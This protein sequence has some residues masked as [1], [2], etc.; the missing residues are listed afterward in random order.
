M[1]VDPAMDAGAVGGDSLP[2]LRPVLVTHPSVET[3]HERWLQVPT[4]SGWWLIDL[5][6]ARLCRTEQ[7]HDPRFLDADH[8][9]PF[10]RVHVGLERIEA[11]LSAGERISALVRSV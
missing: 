5:Q 11:E 2:G 4:T 1:T 3:V 7:A 9:L 10:A 8:W 6:H